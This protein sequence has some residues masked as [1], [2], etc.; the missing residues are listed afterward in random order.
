[1]Q[2]LHEPGHGLAHGPRVAGVEVRAEREVRVDDVGEILL[3]QLAQ[4]LGEIIDDE[5]VALGHERGAQLR[6]LPPR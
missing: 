2:Q 6:H 3:A 4:G 5:A 1:V